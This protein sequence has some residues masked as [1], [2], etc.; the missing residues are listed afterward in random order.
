MNI[1]PSRIWVKRALANYGM[2]IVLLLLCVYYSWATL[3]RQ[4]PSG[5][6]AAT[7]VLSEVTSRAQPGARILIV[8]RTVGR[9]QAFA[10]EL[11]RLLVEKGYI[12][13]QAIEGEPQSAREA[14]TK[15]EKA[16]APIHVIEQQQS[17]Q[18]LQAMFQTLESGA[19]AG[20]ISGIVPLTSCRYW[21]GVPKIY[22]SSVL[23]FD[24]NTSL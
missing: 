4:Q 23:L 8:A 15:L 10:E 11:T 19:R 5:K 7:A 13:I 2:A 14:L 9:D 20:R 1:L 6:E 18:V 12:S 21:Y 3:Q 22:A 17:E 16:P 24:D